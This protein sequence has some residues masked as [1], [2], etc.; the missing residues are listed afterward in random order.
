MIKNSIGKIYI[1]VSSDPNSRLQQHNLKRGAKFTKHISDFE[2][3]F[4]EPYSNLSEARTREIQ[5]K[6]WRRE[7][8]NNLIERY[9]LGLPTKL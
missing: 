7:K 4:L 8:K 1:G 2:I 6:K 9:K 5:I 3:V